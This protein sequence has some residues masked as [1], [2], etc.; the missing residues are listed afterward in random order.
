MKSLWK[1][2]FP[3]NMAERLH[4]WALSFDVF[5]YRQEGSDC[6]TVVHLRKGNRFYK[7]Y[8][9]LGPE[10]KSVLDGQT[11]ICAFSRIC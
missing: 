9:P 5:V 8:S 10:C 3:M 4:S 1:V 7:V 6:F 2:R 11:L